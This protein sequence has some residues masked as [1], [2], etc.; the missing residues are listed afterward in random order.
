[1]EIRANNCKI[2]F[3]DLMF[4][5]NIRFVCEQK[6]FMDISTSKQIIIA[7]GKI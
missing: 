6:C 4:S 3:R 1:M 7:F 2:N 5:E